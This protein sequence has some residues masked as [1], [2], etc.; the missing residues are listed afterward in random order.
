MGLF[1][2]RIKVAK[3]ARDEFEAPVEKVAL[4]SVPT[5]PPEPAP[6]PEEPARGGDYGIDQA[7][8]LM[9]RLPDANAELV[10]RVVKTTLESLRV[11][12]GSIIRVAERK[13]S[14]IRM[15]VDG[16]RKEIAELEAEIATRKS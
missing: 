10:V 15:R 1:E 5:P 9:R 2:K 14:R 4:T 12:V 3:D 8:E 7:I 6:E 16:L 13:E 11:S